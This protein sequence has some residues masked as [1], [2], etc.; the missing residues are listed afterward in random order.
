MIGIITSEMKTSLPLFLLGLLAWVIPVAAQPSGGPY[1]PIAQRYEIPETGHVFFVAP[2][3]EQA[4]SGS[5]VTHPTTLAHAISRAVTGDTIVLRGGVYR[6]GSLR[7]SQGVTLQPFEAEHPI[8]K[9]TRIAT[10]WERTTDGYWRTRWTRL[11]PAVPADWWWPSEENLRKSPPHMFNNDM[12]FRDGDYL[13][14]V[15]TMDDLDASTY[16][17]DYPGGWVYLGADPADSTV[18]ITAHNSAIT[19]TMREAH[20][21]PNDGIGMT[22]RGITFTQFARLALLVEGIEPGAKMDPSEFGKE[23]VGTTFEH[24]TI[25]HCS[26]VAGY[27]RGDGLTMRHC[28]VSDC[29]T[30]GIYVINSANVLLERNIV[31]RINTP[32]K[33]VGYFATAVKIFN[34]SYNVVCRDNL[35]ID[36]P[37]SSGVWYDVGNVDGLFVNNWVETTPNGFFYEISQHAICAGNVF[38]DCDPGIRILN[39]ADVRISQNTFVNADVSFQRSP[40]SHTA[41]DHFGWHASTGPDVHERHGHVFTNNLLYG[42]AE[43]DRPL[44]EMWQNDKLNG[45]LND[46]QVS[47]LDGNVYVRRSDRTGPPLISWGPVTDTEN[48]RMPIAELADLRARHPEFS[49]AAQAFSD[50]RGVLFKGEHLKRYELMSDFPGSATR[51]ALP[52]AVLQS[53]GWSEADFPGAY[54][55]IE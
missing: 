54:R 12:V 13:Q 21:K 9:G 1:G 36:N 17:I 18:E 14:A 48:G 23:I 8:I 11:F 40:R 39:A 5:E 52:E 45:V 38:V 27:F 3:G 34:Q 6:T 28:L 42:D 4:A 33:L 53:L 2:D 24:L 7:L 19:R 43:F 32:E 44:L 47:D 29:G 41:G 35:I 51:V 46:P 30:E 37:H 10:D 49:A 50:Y 15:G 20:G 25:S 26:R 16:F 31:T 55:P 22:I